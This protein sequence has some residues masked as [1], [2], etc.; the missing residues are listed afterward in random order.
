[1][2]ESG[3]QTY[4]I[5]NKRTGLFVYGTDYRYNPPHQRTGMGRAL[6]YPSR[7]KAEMDFDHRQC[8]RDYKIVKVRMEVVNDTDERI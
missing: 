7:E 1:M 4:C 8:G 3:Y 5:I 6:T 2:K